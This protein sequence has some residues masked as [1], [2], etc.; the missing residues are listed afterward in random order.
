MSVK[1]Q[2][3]IEEAI[4]LVTAY[5]ATILLNYDWWVLF[6]LLL[7]PDLSMFGYLIS[8]RVGAGTYNFFH[9]RALAVLSGLCGVVF[10]VDALILAGIILF[11][12]IAMDR[13][14]GYGLKYS[15][16]FHVTHLGTTGRKDK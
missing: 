6:A 4:M 1:N 2:I 11:G 10:H 9:N 7:V 3:K 16:G 5:T 13:L 14:L 12:H 15:E 8:N